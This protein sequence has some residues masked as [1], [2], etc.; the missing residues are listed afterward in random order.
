M[1]YVVASC[2]SDYLVIDFKHIQERAYIQISKNDFGILVLMTDMV[3][4]VLLIIFINRLDEQ[5]LE[6]AE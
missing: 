6:Y 3:V 4:V 5:Q 1:V 2:V